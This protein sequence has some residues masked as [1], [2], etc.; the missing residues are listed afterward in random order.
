MP[1]STI[2]LRDQT[3]TEEDFSRRKGDQFMAVNCTFVRCDFSGSTVKEFVFGG[4]NELSTY[5]GCVFDGARFK[6]TGAD[7]AALDDCTF[8]DVRIENW[9]T[10]TL[11]LTGCTFSGTLRRCSFDGVLP[12]DWQSYLGR[13]RN[14]FEGNDFSACELVEVTFYAGIDLASQRLPAGPHYF[15]LP[16]LAAAVA[17]LEAAAGGWG[18]ADPKAAGALVFVLQRAVGQG[19]TALFAGLADY[20]KRYGEVGERAV[21]FLR[22]RGLEVNPSPPG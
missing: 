10:H 19:R 1:G 11:D 22:D 4:G 13:E 12:A 3:F 7:F 21:E 16:D 8:R 2:L 20:R 14:R 18:A 9:E 6:A 15:W 17:A 5:T